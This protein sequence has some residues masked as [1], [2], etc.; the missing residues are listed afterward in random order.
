MNPATLPLV[1]SIKTNF[2]LRPRSLRWVNEVNEYLSSTTGPSEYSHKSGLFQAI[3]KR[4]VQSFWKEDLIF[5]R[6]HT[7]RSVLTFLVFLF[8]TH[9]CV[10]T[11]NPINKQKP[12][13]LE[14]LGKWCINLIGLYAAIGETGLHKIKSLVLIRDFTAAENAGDPSRELIFTITEYL[15]GWIID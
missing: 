2:P 1:Y 11:R 13:M 7:S 5:T 8:V 14:Q 6:P 3:I 10:F 9:I 15:R 12:S 4:P